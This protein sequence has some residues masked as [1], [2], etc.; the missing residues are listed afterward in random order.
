M[1][2]SSPTLRRLMQ[3]TLR[4]GTAAILLAGVSLAACSDDGN[5]AAAS[6]TVVSGSSQTG[7]VSTALVSPLVVKVVDEDGDAVSGATVT[8]A[9]T[10]GGVI[11]SP[12]VTTNSEGRAQTTYVLGATAGAQTVTA[13]T[14]GVATAA[15]FN[16]TATAVVGVQ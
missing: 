10:S 15:T 5:D 14:A 8:F 9:T 2:S 7:V 3:R 16:L 11:G 4:L 6:I 1:R 13:T 12:T